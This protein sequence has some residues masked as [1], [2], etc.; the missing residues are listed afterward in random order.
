ML[1][2]FARKEGSPLQVIGVPKT[3]D[4]DMKG[5]SI[6][7]SFGFDTA[8]KVYAELI[9]NIN[10]IIITNIRVAIAC[11]QY[12]LPTPVVQC[13]CGVHKTHQHQLQFTQHS[14]LQVRMATLRLLSTLQSVLT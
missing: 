8:C 13:A 6:E 12:D 11:S 7:T 2:E 9:G 5:G 14:A 3:I 10:L 4:G 1:A